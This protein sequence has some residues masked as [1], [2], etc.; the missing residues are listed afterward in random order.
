MALTEQNMAGLVSISETLRVI[1]NRVGRASTWLLV[2]LVIITMWDVVARKLVWI[3]IWM[4]ANFGSF[5]ESTLMQEMEWHLHTVVFFFCLVLGYGYTHNRHVRVDFL[6][7]N[8]TFKSKAK[9]EFYGNLLFMLPFTLICVYFSWIYMV[10]SYVI[11]EV[12]AS[13]VGLSNRWIIKTFL[14][15]GYF[16]LFL[17]GMSVMIQL[18]AVIWGDNKKKLDLMVLDYDEQKK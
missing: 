1:V 9:V 14:P 12:S 18:I 2:P 3:Q 13:L 4:V 11:N 8:F 10:D 16:F 5:F 6:R 17:G 7:E 15:I